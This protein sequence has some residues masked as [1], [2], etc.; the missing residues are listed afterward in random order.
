VRFLLDEMYSPDIALALQ[1][2]GTDAVS[3]HERSQLEGEPDDREILRAATREGRVLV[4]NN[5]KDLVPIVDEFGLGG[6]M[7][8]GVLL[9]SDVT[10][11]RTREMIALMVRSLAAFA[12]DR[13]DDEMR[14]DCQFLPRVD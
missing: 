10:F 1:R 7:H 2:K 14:D 13:A 5:A 6:E 4:S 3:V 11:P 12:A 8:L 9:T